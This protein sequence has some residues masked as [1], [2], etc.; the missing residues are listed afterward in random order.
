MNQAE[1]AAILA[2][3][4]MFMLALIAWLNR[5]QDRINIAF[6]IFMVLKAVDSLIRLK[7]ISAITIEEYQYWMQYIFIFFNIFCLALLYFI[8]ELTGYIHRLSEKVL[9]IT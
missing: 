8:L 3:F 1:V 6:A 4:L 7:L 9:F 2:S 5:R